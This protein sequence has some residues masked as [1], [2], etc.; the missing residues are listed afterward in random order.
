MTEPSL[1]FGP[2][3]CTFSDHLS[4]DSK[5]L[6]KKLRAIPDV[7][8]LKEPTVPSAYPIDIQQT[9]NRNQRQESA[10]HHHLIYLCI[11]IYMYTYSNYLS[12]ALSNPQTSEMSH[13]QKA[14]NQTRACSQER[15]SHAIVSDSTWRMTSRSGDSGDGD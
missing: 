4:C 12:F 3:N 10:Y 1:E 14:L 8:K 5:N 2:P 13:G 15:T 11:Y 9:I 6:G 7:S